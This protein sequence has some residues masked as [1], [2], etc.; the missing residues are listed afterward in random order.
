MSRHKSEEKNWNISVGE[1]V[2]A[3]ASIIFKFKKFRTTEIFPSAGHPSK[4][5][6][7]GIRAL[8]REVIK[9]PKVELAKTITSVKFTTWLSVCQKKPICT[10]P[11]F[12]SSQEDPQAWSAPNTT[13][14]I[15]L[16]A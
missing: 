10:I 6:K 13:V 11:R 2:Q 9:N 15:S 12:I 4:M 1:K 5:S 3:V 8:F 16:T 14:P 7:Q